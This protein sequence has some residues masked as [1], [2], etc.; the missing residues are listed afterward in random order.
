MGAML[1][2]AALLWIVDGLDHGIDAIRQRK[3]ST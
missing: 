1:L 3:T 2:G